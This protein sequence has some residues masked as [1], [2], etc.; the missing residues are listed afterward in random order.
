MLLTIPGSA[1]WIAEV[2]DIA[3]SRQ[4]VELVHEEIAIL[5]LRATMDLENRWILLLR[6]KPWRRHDPSLQ[7]VAVA[8]VE[9]YLFNLAKIEPGEERLVQMCQLPDVAHL[10]VAHPDLPGVS[11][12]AQEIGHHRLPVVHSECADAASRVDDGVECPLVDRDRHQLLASV[13]RDLKIQNL[14]ISGPHGRHLE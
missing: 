7:I 1:P 13:F 12:G 9:P 11:H 3:A 14:P 2:D 10:H 5:V 4:E 6:V 8:G